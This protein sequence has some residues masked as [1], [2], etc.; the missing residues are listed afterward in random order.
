MHCNLD[1]NKQDHLLARSIGSFFARFPSVSQP[2]SSVP[3]SPVRS[4]VRFVVRRA[5]S[6][7]VDGDDGDE[8]TDDDE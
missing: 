6:D 1:Y 8:E 3:K 5:V 4:F 7:A 2:V